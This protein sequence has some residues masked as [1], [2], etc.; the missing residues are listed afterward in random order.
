MSGGE[1][2]FSGGTQSVGRK[3]TKIVVEKGNRWGRTTISKK[4]C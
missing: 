3:R 4:D 2:A 1:S